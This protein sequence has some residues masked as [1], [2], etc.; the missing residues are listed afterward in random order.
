MG[1][2]VYRVTSKKI[3]C[4]D[5]QLANIATYAYKPYFSMFDDKKTNAKLHFKTGC[6]ASDRMASKGN[7]TERFV[8]DGGK[9]V[10]AN[11]TGRG[12]F[13]DSYIGSREY[14]LINGVTI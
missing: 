8:L 6:T 11:T 1:I 3:K 7:I 4:S 13:Y 9:E 12:S 14:P 10:Y 5:G 2:Y